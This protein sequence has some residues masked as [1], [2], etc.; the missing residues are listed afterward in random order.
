MKKLIAAALMAVLLTGCFGK[1]RTVPFRYFSIVTEPGVKPAVV[2]IPKSI[3]IIDFQAAARYGYEIVHRTD[4]FGIGYEQ[5]DR[6]VERPEEMTRRVYASVFDGRN[7]FKEVIFGVATAPTDYILEGYVLQFDEIRA[8]STWTARF[9]IK[10]TLSSP[11]EH[12]IIWTNLKTVE[13]R[14]ESNITGA[15]AKAMSAAVLE[16]AQDALR[17]VEA[18]LK[19]ENNIIAE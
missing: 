13:R 8:D 6:W 4:A 11:L 18:I 12:R 2:T 9:S 10:L 5:F 17:E 14:L 16:S 19:K 3:W 15:L 1:L 7:F